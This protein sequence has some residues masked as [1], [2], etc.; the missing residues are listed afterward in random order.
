MKNSN[1]GNARL[2]T[3]SALSEVLDD[4]LMLSDCPSLQPA[5]NERDTAFA[6]HLAY[7]VCRWKPALEW[8]AVQ[9]L[10]RPLKKRDADISRLML[11]GLHQLW[12]DQTPDHAA[13]HE[14]AECARAIAK[15]WAV[16]LL[17]AV[18]RRFLREKESLLQRLQTQPERLAHPPWMLE[19]FRQDWP[20][21]WESLAASN[22]CP[23]GL[24][25]R[26]NTQRAVIDDVIT[27]LEQAGSEVQRHPHAPQALRI[28]PALRVDRIPGFAQGHLS[29]QDPA[30]Q[31]AAALLNAQP[32]DRVL[33]ACAA[34]GGKTCHI[35]E[36]TP[37]VELT[38]LD[39]HAGR[40]ERIRENL[41]RLG[42]SCD[43][44]VADAARPDQWWDDRPFDRILLDAPCSALGVIRRHPEIKWLRSAQQVEQVVA[45][46]SR[47]LQRL[48]PLL[49]VGGILVYAT[50]SVLRRENSKQ[51]H[52]FLSR[53]PDAEVS[54]SE[55]GWGF[56]ASPGVQI[57]PGSSNMDGF[58]YAVLRK[59]E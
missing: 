59:L 40:L 33:D 34:P 44:R 32:G 13:V 8:L 16:G 24:W 30:A 43:L 47:L 1:R 45:T 19:H 25:L 29:V 18:L 35:L 21:D 17:N 14:T 11:M 10:Q 3:L 5:A 2:T 51:I 57:L 54:G 39:S 31:L 52:G 48:W 22:N 53:H 20:D 50:C 23:A 55:A 4:G 7:G 38:A 49:A 36:M 41:Q 42:L 6:R 28:S 12:Q 27:G 37:D 15:P 58:Y 46:Q 56:P 9:L 26:V